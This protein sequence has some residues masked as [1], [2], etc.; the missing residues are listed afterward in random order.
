MERTVS[1]T[2][3][4]Q[5]FLLFLTLDAERGYRPGFKPFLGDLSSAVFA[6][7]KGSLVNTIESLL[8]LH[9]KLPFPVAN[10]QEEIPVG[11]PGRPVGGVRKITCGQ[12]GIIDRLG[13]LLQKSLHLLQKKLFEMFS[14]FFVQP[15]SH[16]KTK[17]RRKW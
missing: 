15:P 14:G 5:L 6:D 10:P 1:H 11:F 8:D 9:N 13:G 3:L 2:T 17:N 4:F 12:R 16:L 7:T